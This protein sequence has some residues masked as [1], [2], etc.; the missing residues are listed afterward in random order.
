MTHQKTSHSPSSI[1]AIVCLLICVAT[2]A[3]SA[4]QITA[5]VYL[6][7]TDKDGT[8]THFGSGFF[9]T[10]TLIATSSNVVRGAAAGTAT[11]VGK[12]AKSA[13]ESVVAVDPKNGLVLLKVAAS[14]V[15]P[16]PLGDSDAVKKGDTVYVA[17]RAEEGL[18]GII[19]EYKEGHFELTTTIPPI[20]SGAPV[21]N[22]GGEV[23][24][25]CFS[26]QERNFVV[27]SNALKTLL[28]Q[29][30]QTKHLQG[31]K[32]LGNLS[33]EFFYRSGSAH[34]KLKDY[35]AAIADFTEAIKR[36]PDHA[37]AYNNRGRAKFAL[38]QHKEA[39]AGYA[40]A[41][42]NRG[43]VKQALRQYSLKHY[44]AAIADYNVAIR[45]D[46]D[47]IYA[48]GNRGLAKYSLKQYEAAIADFNTVIRLKPN[49][50]PA[51]DNR[52]LSYL[53]LSQ[54]KAAI[55]N[56]D[57]AIQ[58]D[59]DHIM[60]YNNR[61][62]ANIYL[63]QYE[64][65]I[66]DFDKVLTQNPDYWDA[67][68]NRGRAKYEL[69]QYAAAVVD[70]DVLI[71]TDRNSHL[72]YYY[73]GSAK[74]E[75]GQYM[76]AIADFNI[77]VQINPQFVYGFHNRGKAKAA[78]EHYRA[79]I[80]DYDKA[81]RYIGI[82]PDFLESRGDAKAK[83]GQNDAAIADY[84]EAAFSRGMTNKIE[85][86]IAEA[87][88]NFKNAMKLAEQIKNLPLKMQAERMLRDLESQ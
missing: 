76:A 42:N 57:I 33:A 40:V 46:P 66:L 18:E 82:H 74:Y 61:G 25:V 55:S 85:G 10:D 71:Q 31:Q 39:A 65:A 43:G 80:E 69:G 20:R 19:G 12:D 3:T 9:V 1:I 4:D 63:E 50:A 6:E 29:A 64:V 86:K 75:L 72:D 70:F 44:K 34:F 48:Y 7:L 67:Y 5:T 59:P 36:K 54:Y 38:G 11:L 52:G 14:N 60:P 21:L 37:D 77:S 84:A 45:L 78:L 23:I 26:L 53:Y 16:L 2:T 41:Y 79:A 68:Y 15:A 81:I 47:F 56:F 13:I 49:Y 30:K 27:P 51:Y 8:A 62:R 35:A 24:G 22:R 87:E 73:R 32:P 88:K 58:L 17:G 83:L 28:N